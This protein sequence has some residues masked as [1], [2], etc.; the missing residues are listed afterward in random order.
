MGERTQ[1]RLGLPL[2]QTVNDLL[3]AFVY[4]QQDGGVEATKILAAEDLATGLAVAQPALIPDVLFGAAAIL[5]VEERLARHV[6]QCWSEG[7]TSLH[8][9]RA[10]LS[11]AASAGPVASMAGGMG[12]GESS[13][14]RLS[15]ID[16]TY[17]SLAESG[18]GAMQA[19]RP[20]VKK[21]EPI[22]AR[23]WED[24]DVSLSAKIRRSL[25]A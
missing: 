24:L 13:V 6:L 20:S 9:V 5:A 25:V 22:D 11:V 17:R 15:A 18:A 10:G 4:V 21:F 16:A 12:Q 2:A 14:E 7:R 1:N 8:T 3:A 19:T 23:V